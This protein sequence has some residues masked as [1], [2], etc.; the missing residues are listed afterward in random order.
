LASKLESRESLLCLRGLKLIG[1]TLAIAAVL[2]IPIVKMKGCPPSIVL[3]AI[4]LKTGELKKRQVVSNQ[5]SPTNKVR[6]NNQCHNDFVSGGPFLACTESTVFVVWLSE[7]DNGCVLPIV[8][9]ASTDLRTVSSELSLSGNGSSR[10]ILP[11]IE[12][13][14]DSAAVIVV[15]E[16]KEGFIMD[17]IFSC[18]TTGQHWDLVGVLSRGP[19]SK[20]FWPGYSRTV[21][22]WGSLVLVPW[23]SGLTGGQGLEIDAV[24]INE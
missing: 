12:T 6:L 14:F 4:D 20:Q 3:Y 1:G 19:I 9:T 21:A 15:A 8:C 22:A 23:P 7:R 11:A 24:D 13:I 5:Y 17:N 18:T 16:V 10:F 2:E